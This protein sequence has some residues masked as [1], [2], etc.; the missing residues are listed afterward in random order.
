M[1]YG[2]SRLLFALLSSA[3]PLLSLNEVRGAPASNKK[4]VRIAVIGSTPPSV[5]AK[6]PDKQ[7]VKRVI[8]F[9]R[10]RL[11]QVLPDKPDLIVI[12]ECSDR[13]SGWGGE[14]LR[15]YY[16]GR[17]HTVERFFSEVARKNHCYVVYPAVR[18]LEDG[19]WYNT[20]TLIDRNGKVVGRYK[21]NFPT[22][23]EIENGIRPGT[24]AVVLPCDFGRVGFAI[25]F[26]L[27]FDELLRRYA[28]L[29]PDLIVFCSMYHGGLR[30]AQ[31]A[32]A[33]RA[34]FV[35]AIM[36][37][38]PSQI[39]D[40]LGRVLASTTNYFDFAVTEINLDCALAHLDYN[41][42]RLRRLKEKYG[43]QVRISDP[44]FVGSVLITSEHPT[45]TVEDMLQEFAI[46]KLDHYL[47]RA[48]EVRKRA[49][50]ESDT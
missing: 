38:C 33:C 32:Y 21:K 24:E 23:G 17:G 50:K 42:S 10:G 20:S 8:D 36:R 3:V 37:S 27:N 22:I 19:K 11:R 14:R 47:D 35:G 7:V 40:P 12:P 25:C 5:D 13:P 49:L 30:Q 43:P 2:S 46:E 26:D 41:W 16:K 6:L 34:H 4:H 18:R 39:R 9:W 1:R 48:R 28:V 45:L 44:G 29:R 31:W 15:R